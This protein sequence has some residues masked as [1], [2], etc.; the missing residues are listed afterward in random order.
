MAR[1][2]KYDQKSNIIKTT[3]LQ[4]NDSAVPLFINGK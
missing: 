2:D 4:T 3:V 1:D